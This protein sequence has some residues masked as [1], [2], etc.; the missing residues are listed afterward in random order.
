MN[1]LKI[2]ACNQP[3]IVQNKNNTAPKLLKGNLKSDIFV[4]NTKPADKISFSGLNDSY[5]LRILKNLFPYTQYDLANNYI[6]KEPLLKSLEGFVPEELGL[7]NIHLTENIQDYDQLDKI[8]EFGEKHL[9]NNVLLESYVKDLRSLGIKDSC[10]PEY[11]QIKRILDN[12]NY[13][14]LVDYNML[15]E[16]SKKALRKEASK[17]SDKNYGVSSENVVNTALT[18]KKNLDEKYGEGNY[19]F[20]SIGQSPALYAN[21]L[22]S[23]GVETKVIMYSKTFEGSNLSSSNERLELYK[24]Y[25]DKLG[26]NSE[27]IK[28]S[29]KVYVFTDHAYMG[30]TIKLFK[31][32]LKNK[33]IGLNLKNINI[34]ELK[35]LA[36]TKEADGQLNLQKNNFINYMSECSLKKY[37]YIPYDPKNEYLKNFRTQPKSN[38]S[39]NAKIFR[40]ALI[41]ELHKRGAIN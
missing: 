24:D 8:Q 19:V 20:C 25:F 39:Y 21:T 40:F 27:K 34:I 31:R 28:N 2:Y 9:K 17:I 3:P 12:S 1:I 13:M 11:Q 33:Q 30:E 35:E 5:E 32:L 29:G 6:T 22:E 4:R 16:K 18:I 7:Y 26:L 14:Q 37:S 41:D 23:L 36:C 10:E 38:E 15:S